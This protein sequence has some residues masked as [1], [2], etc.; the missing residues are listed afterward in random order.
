M[1]HVRNWMFGYFSNQYGNPPVRSKPKCMLHEIANNKE[2]KKDKTNRIPTL[3]KYMVLKESEMQN[4]TTRLFL[5]FLCSVTDSKK[6]I[7][8]GLKKTIMPAL[9]I[10]LC[11]YTKQTKHNNSYI[12]ETKHI[13]TT[14]ITHLR[15]RSSKSKFSIL[16]GSGS[17][18]FHGTYISIVFKPSER[19]ISTRSAG[20]HKCVVN[21][22]LFLFCLFL[23]LENAKVRF[24]NNANMTPW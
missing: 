3:H 19:T 13:T 10:V 20:A 15:K 23:N 4:V 7:L 12:N 8:P 5:Y 6:I 22:H 16:P 21:K 14:S 11:I 17:W 2:R 18:K 1:S 24:E 9:W